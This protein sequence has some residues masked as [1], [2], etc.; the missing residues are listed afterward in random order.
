M[1]VYIHQSLL[2]FLFLLLLCF[3]GSHLE[4][5]E[6]VLHILPPLIPLL[7]RLPYFFGRTLAIAA[8]FLAG[9]RYLFAEP[10]PILSRHDRFEAA[11]LGAAQCRK[12]RHDRMHKA[13]CQ[14]TM[15]RRRVAKQWRQM[16]DRLLLDVRRQISTDARQCLIITSQYRLFFKG[17]I[18]IIQRRG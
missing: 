2:V 12:G 13:F 6:P 18:K 17:K 10:W 14:D 3:F 9:R 8:I 7:D 15:W 1:C 5:A 11:G 16:S 4:F